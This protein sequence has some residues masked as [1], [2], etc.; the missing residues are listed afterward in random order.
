MNRGMNKHNNDNNNDNDNNQVRAAMNKN[1]N[2]ANDEKH[3]ENRDLSSIN[4]SF[5]NGNNSSGGGS[6]KSDGSFQSSNIEIDGDILNNLSIARLLAKL[7]Q[8]NA[9]FILLKQC[10]N[11][12]G[13][14]KTR[15]MGIEKEMNNVAALCQLNDNDKMNKN[16][17]NNN[18]VSDMTTSLIGI[19]QLFT[20]SRSV[21][22]IDANVNNISNNNNNNSM[23]SSSGSGEISEH[24]VRGRPSSVARERS[25]IA[26]NYP[27]D[28]DEDENEDEN[29]DDNNN[30]NDKD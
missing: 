4:N 12:M 1:I 2:F 7:G 9:S 15:K 20:D 18:S 24:Y 23:N 29:E 16:S 6:S 30:D 25:R 11:K 10:V 27:P 3:N 19:G 22:D 21:F 8:H 26:V 5:K 14:E 13:S 28:G 17:G